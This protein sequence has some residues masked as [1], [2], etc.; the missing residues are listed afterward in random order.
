VRVVGEFPDESGI[1]ARLGCP[2]R[3]ADDDV[4]P[5]ET[6]REVGQ[7]SQ[8]RNIRPMHVVDHKRDRMLV[9][10]GGRQPVQAM[11]DRE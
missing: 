2:H 9:G 6:A 11:Q 4:E 10:D 3:D 1:R 7:E 8:G 5:L